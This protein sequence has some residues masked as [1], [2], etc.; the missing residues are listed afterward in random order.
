MDSSDEL[1]AKLILGEM[2]EDYDKDLTGVFYSPKLNKTIFL[3]NSLSQNFEDNLL[4]NKSRSLLGSY[5]GHVAQCNVLIKSDVNMFERH[6][7][8]KN[9]L[10]GLKVVPSKYIFNNNCISF[11]GYKFSLPVDN[12]NDY[13]LF[14]NV[15]KQMNFDLGFLDEVTEK[16]QK[17]MSGFKGLENDVKRFD[18]YGKD[19]ILKNLSVSAVK[20]LLEQRIIFLKKN[21]VV[22][23]AL[24]KMDELY[25][26]Q[27]EKFG[28][29]Y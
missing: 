21:E 22:R 5:G 14:N 8:I 2:L 13:N 12:I 26:R 25:L 10:V 1:F 29:E 20:N 3:R 11:L 23:D 4:F 7:L 19:N 18:L 24:V 16:L 6:K 15:F 17:R 9:N 27:Y 28:I